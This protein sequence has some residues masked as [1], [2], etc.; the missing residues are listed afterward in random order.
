ML[1]ITFIKMLPLFLL[2]VLSACS[3]SDDLASPEQVTLGFF[4][5]IYIERDVEKAER[6]VAPDLKE[7]MNHYH[8]ASQVQRHVLGLSMSQVSIY[9]DEVDIDFF[10]KFTNDVT[11]KV[12]IEGLKGGENW[13]DD[14][15][16][17]LHKQ[18][19]SWIIVEILLEKGRI[20]G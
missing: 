12:K 20:E 16:I 18:A 19:N 3:K 14:R 11:V 9:I 13:I 6:F 2:F 7:I 1:K 10:R 5:A 15:T 8:I 4:N 17:R